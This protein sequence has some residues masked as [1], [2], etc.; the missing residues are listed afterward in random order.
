MM[1]VVVF[2]W[3]GCLGDSFWW[4]GVVYGGIFPCI[5]EFNVVVWCRGVNGEGVYVCVSGLF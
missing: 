3:E 5:G 4:R 1:L 2:S